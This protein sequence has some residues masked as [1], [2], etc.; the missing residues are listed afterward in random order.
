MAM[1]YDA[2]VALPTFDELLK[3]LIY[4]RETQDKADEKITTL[5]SKMSEYD[6]MIEKE[7]ILN[8]NS[9]LVQKYD[10]YKNEMNQ[11]AD[12]V[13]QYGHTRGFSKQL[14]KSVANF[15]SI[16]P[17]YDQALKN[18]DQATRI[19]TQL[20]LDSDNIL[21]EAD[22][23]N[24]IN[25]EYF[26]NNDVYTPANLKGQNIT[27]DIAK[28]WDRVG[29]VFSSYSVSGG[30]GKY[31]THTQTTGIPPNIMNAVQDIIKTGNYD[32]LDKFKLSSTEKEALIRGIAETKTILTNYGSNWDDAA[33]TRIY[34]YANRGLAVASQEVRKNKGL[35]P[36]YEKPLTPQQQALQD[37]QN[38]SFDLLMEKYGISKTADGKWDINYKYK[39]DEK[40][41]K[42]TTELEPLTIEDFNKIATEFEQ[43]NIINQGKNGSNRGN[44]RPPIT[45]KY[46]DQT[47]DYEYTPSAPLFVKAK[48]TE[49]NGNKPLYTIIEPVAGS[50][51]LGVTKDGTR[52][53]NGPFEDFV[54]QTFSNNNIPLNTDLELSSRLQSRN[55]IY[56]RAGGPTGEQLKIFNTSNKKSADENSSGHPTKI[57]F[58]DDV[59]YMVKN[60]DPNTAYYEIYSPVKITDAKE[61]TEHANFKQRGRPNEITSYYS[62]YMYYRRVYPTADGGVS[63]SN[64]DLIGINIGRDQVKKLFET[65]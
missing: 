16:I 22:N 17:M 23:P 46:G 6:A 61:P 56:V 47:A 33:L 57:Q 48:G 4:I 64:T 3:P 36:T 2:K 41:G 65:P 11:M 62:D 35:N 42:Y 9:I 20:K 55:L 60:Y 50:V 40:T 30:N 10:T 14:S 26:Y 31:A 18:K 52:V 24:N 15:S 58:I 19:W 54:W 59:Q 7:R 44:N 8:P 12:Q 28:T 32:L 53:V 25:Y 34:D 43:N 1:K 29:R 51:Y 39:I 63:Y 5:N 13:M 45:S 27:Q 49:N 37:I 38:K 21:N